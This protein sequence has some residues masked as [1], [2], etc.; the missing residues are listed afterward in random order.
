[1]NSRRIRCFYFSPRLPLNCDR[2]KPSSCLPTVGCLG[3][4]Q[5]HFRKYFP[6]QTAAH[7]LSPSK[8]C[9]CS[10]DNMP[11]AMVPRAY[12]I[13]P[14][15]AL[16]LISCFSHH[17]SHAPTRHAAAS[18]RDGAGPAPGPLL[19]QCP[20]L[21][22]SSLQPSPPHCLKRGFQNKALLISTP[23]PTSR[24]ILLLSITQFSFRPQ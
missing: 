17:F 2:K 7:M 20:L 22:H 24:Q 5:R 1:M 18:C 16:P 13:R 19:G 23:P 10:E 8:G 6:R 14:R 12:S 3:Y 9:P 4:M 21:E 15:S 11:F